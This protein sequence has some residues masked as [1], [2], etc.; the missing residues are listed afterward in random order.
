[1]KNLDIY[2]INY[3]NPYHFNRHNQGEIYKLSIQHSYNNPSIYYGGASSRN[4]GTIIRDNIKNYR[5]TSF[6]NKTEERKNSISKNYTSLKNNLA[7][8]K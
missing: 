1:M 8:I 7:P 5:S 4:Y 6:D 3:N 2:D